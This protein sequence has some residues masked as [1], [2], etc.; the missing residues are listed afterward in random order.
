MLKSMAVLALTGLMAATPAWVAVTQEKPPADVRKRVIER[1]ARLLVAETAAGERAILAVEPPKP[2]QDLEKE[3]IERPARLLVAEAA[4]GDRAV[5][6]AKQPKPR[7]DPGKGRIERPAKLFV[8]E[9]VPVEPAKKAGPPEDESKREIEQPVE[10]VIASNPSASAL[11]EEKKE[12]STAE[13]PKVEP[14]KVRWRDDF[15][16]ACAASAGSG[17]PVLLFQLM[18][19]LDHRFT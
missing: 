9:T 7:L 16:A 5:Q 12:L 15:Q 14:G 8:A 10:S 4:A 1:P 2:G 13:N 19:Q 17:K 6:A 18:G 3:R 11:V